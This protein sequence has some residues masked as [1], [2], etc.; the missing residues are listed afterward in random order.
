VGDLLA[1][2]VLS[3]LGWHRLLGQALVSAEMAE[4]D[5]PRFGAWVEN[6]G[7]VGARTLAQQTAAVLLHD[8]GGRLGE[9]RVPTLVLAGDADRLVPLENSMRLA[10]A[11]PGAR[12][13]V[14]RGAGHCFPL[15]RFEETVREVAGFFRDCGSVAVAT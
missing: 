14:L 2:G 13:A 8:S 9:I 15:E 11:I 5:L 10:E 3:R 12:L 4:T 6:A 7:R 1:G